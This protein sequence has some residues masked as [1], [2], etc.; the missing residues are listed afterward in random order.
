MALMEE[1]DHVE[2]VR[3]VTGHTTGERGAIVS[4]SDGQALIEFVDDEGTTRDLAEIP[5]DALRPV[6]QRSAA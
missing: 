4:L 2:L 1:H 3:A 6:T 5:L